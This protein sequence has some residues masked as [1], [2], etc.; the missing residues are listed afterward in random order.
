MP[1]RRPMRVDR[2]WT[3]LSEWGT[4]DERGVGSA[5]NART[6]GGK[7]SAR[8]FAWSQ[9]GL[10]PLLRGKGEGN[11]KRL[12]KALT[13]GPS[14]A[15]KESEEREHVLAWASTTRPLSHRGLG[16]RGREHG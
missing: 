16:G 8:D 4:R 15:V 12:G 13:R 14:L 9:A 11:G 5:R 6:W 10:G 7:G 2:G 1:G 3:E